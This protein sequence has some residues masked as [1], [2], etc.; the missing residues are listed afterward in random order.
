[1]SV[2]LIEQTFLINEAYTF[3]LRTWNLARGV[4]M[5]TS[6]EYLLINLDALLLLCHVEFLLFS[7]FS[8]AMSNFLI[9]IY[10][11]I[12][13]YQATIFAPCLGVH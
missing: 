3:P 13:I 8:F 2:D 5:V 11:L 7:H 12:Y 4:H 10:I 9:Y 1:M 6:E